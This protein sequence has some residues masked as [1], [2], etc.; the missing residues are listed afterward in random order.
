M[1]VIN[2]R[3]FVHSSAAALAAGVWSWPLASRSRAE[4]A[5]DKLSIAMI[6]I[7]GQGGLNLKGVKSQN[8]V[9]LCDVDDKRAGSAYSDYPQAKKYYD[10]RRMFDEMEGEID[11]VVVSTPDH[12]HYHPALWALERKK[13]LYL[14]KPLCHSVWETRRIVDLAREQ[15]VATQLG[16]QRHA[17]PGL[18]QSVELAKS[19]VLGKIHTVYS[20]IDSDR[21]MP[22]IPTGKETPPE[23]FKWDLWL[24]PAK[25]RDYHAHYAPYNWRFWWDFGTGDTGNWGF[26]ILD[27]PYWALGL[28]HPSS[29]ELLDGGQWHEQTTPKAMSTRFTFAA[30]ERHGPIELYWQQGVPSILAEHKLSSKGMNNLFVGDEG[31]LLCGFGGGRLLPGD[32]F[33]GTKAEQTLEPSP[34][35]HKEWF[36]ACR[37]GAPASCNFEYSGPLAETALLGNVAFRARGG[38]DWDAANLKAR[39]NA[40]ADEYL[41]SYFREGWEG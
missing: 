22:E 7:G 18:R 20:W 14:E 28:K 35:F 33:A 41:K 8:I 25:E 30:S 4:S 13:H 27:I 6:G 15:G 38:F 17:E 29:V 36:A 21:G 11:A 12:T 16:V 9:A 23:G 39:G 37:G 5:N 10:F 24:G 3:K 26:H 40:A 31:M 34:G 32:K 1:S 2:R 19:G